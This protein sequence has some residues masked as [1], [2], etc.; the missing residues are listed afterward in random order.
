[1]QQQRLAQPVADFF[2]FSLLISF[3]SLP[4][5]YVYYGHAGNFSS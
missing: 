3:A 4:F 2:P 1:M 5:F